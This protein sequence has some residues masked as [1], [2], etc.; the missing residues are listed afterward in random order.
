VRL[1]I[2]NWAQKHPA[3]AATFAG[4]YQQICSAGAALLIIPMLINSLGIEVAGLWI[5]LQ[6][7]IAI[8]TLS[9][10]GFSMAITRQVAHSFFADHDVNHLS[11]DLIKT[12]S[13]WK[14]VAT[15]YA[16]SKTIFMWV[17]LVSI[18]LFIIA[19]ELVLPQ[20]NLLPNPT[21]ETTLVW[22]LLAGSFA[23]I[24]QARLSQAFLDGL[25]YMYLSRLISGTYQ[26][27][28]GLFS[29]LSL[30]NGFGLT[31]LAVVL[32]AS[33]FLQFFAMYMS[34]KWISEDQLITHHQHRNPLVIKL[35]KVAF[36]FGLVSSGVYLVG[37]VQVPLLGAILGPSVIAS[38]FIAFK[39]SQVLNG[40]VLQ[41]VTA[42]MPMFTKQCAQ[43]RWSDAKLRMYQTLIA[44]TGL[45]IAVAIFLYFISP[46]IVKWWIGPGH[47]IEG[48]VLIAF[49]I[50]YLITCLLALPAQFVLASGRNPFS[51]TTILHGVLTLL[52]MV[53]LCPKIGLMGVPLAGLAG[54][55]FTNMWKNPLEAWNTWKILTCNECSIKNINLLPYR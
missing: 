23:F 31:G 55:M 2:T 3:R 43:G 8:F 6:G 53:F 50:N 22:Y 24:F 15:I 14:G 29:M 18:L 34:L 52:G 44:G 42:Q 20:T 5:S 36:P 49:T 28:C 51:L 13:G 41:I 47:Y 39:I 4:W 40:A 19:N 10:F 17:M 37:A 11:S 32:L 26:L 25:G 38:I 46:T 9:D 1:K 7:I 33:S 12:P 35:F 16:A 30:W 48:P 27:I 21:T 45:Q 54:L